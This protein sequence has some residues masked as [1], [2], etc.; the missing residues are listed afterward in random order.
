AIHADATTLPE[1]LSAAGWETAAFI[2]NYLASSVFGHARGFRTFHFY[3]EDGARRRELY[4]PS[5]ALYRRVARWLSKAPRQPFFLYVHA[6]DPHFPSWPPRR[7]APAFLPTGVSYHAA[8]AVADHARPF[9]L[10]NDDWGARPSPLSADRVAV[11][12]DLYDG[13]LRTADHWFGRLIEQ[14]AH[15]GLLDDTLVVLTSD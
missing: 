8:L 5:S 4:L 6:T 14:L 3:P 9:F 13:D 10:G 2:T 7:T 15:A 12:R 11:L 1:M